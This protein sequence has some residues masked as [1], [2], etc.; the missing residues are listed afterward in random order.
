MGASY[1]GLYLEGRFVDHLSRNAVFFVCED[2]FGGC[3]LITNVECMIGAYQYCTVLYFRRHGIQVDT[4]VIQI[5]AIFIN[6]L[7]YHCTTVLYLI[8]SMIGFFL[9]SCNVC[10][11]QSTF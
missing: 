2:V 3:D 8:G 6:R 4:L 5:M 1:N 10:F 11:K 9:S 7:K